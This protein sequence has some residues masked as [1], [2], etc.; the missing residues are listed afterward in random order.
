M[1][2]FKMENDIEACSVD[3]SFDQSPM[4]GDMNFDLMTRYYQILLNQ[5]EGS[6]GEFS[7]KAFFEN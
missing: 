2:D 3:E 4:S 1:E 6:N 5:I 7:W